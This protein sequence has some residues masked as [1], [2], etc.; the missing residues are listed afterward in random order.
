M[1]SRISVCTLWCRICVIS[2]GPFCVFQSNAE[3][4]WWCWMLLR[5]VTRSEIVF[6]TRFSGVSVPMVC[7]WRC[8]LSEYESWCFV[9]LTLWICLPEHTMH[10]GHMMSQ[11]VVCVCAVMYS[12]VSGFIYFIVVVQFEHRRYRH[13]VL[14]VI[15]CSICW[16][17]TCCFRVQSSMWCH[18]KLRIC[19][20]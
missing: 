5:C 16:G 19:V 9:H 14:R 6:W 1:C 20:P 8:S 2:E 12:L 10:R 4:M 18:C 17:N 3:R 7:V 15:V 11:W 13:E